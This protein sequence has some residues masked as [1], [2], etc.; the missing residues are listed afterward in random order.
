MKDKKSKPK[1][2][3]EPDVIFG[4]YYGYY[5]CFFKTYAGEIDRFTFHYNSPRGEAM[6][7]W[8]KYDGWTA[9]DLGS[10][11]DTRNGVFPQARVQ[12]MIPAPIR[13]EEL[14]AFMDEV[15]IDA[16]HRALI[17]KHLDALGT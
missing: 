6:A 4:E 9:F 15:K 7:R 17:L 12:Q 14:L 10:M 13:P 8:T 1:F 5:I 2:S 11:Q 16:K 3:D